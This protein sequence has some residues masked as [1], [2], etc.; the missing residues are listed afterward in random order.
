MEEHRE[1]LIGDAFL[2]QPTQKRRCDQHDSNPRLRKAAINGSHQ[3]LTK[4][5][6]LFA[7]PYR[8]TVLYK[9]VMKLLCCTLSVIPR[10]TQEHIPLIE[11]WRA[12]LKDLPRRS[13]GANFLVGVKDCG[14]RS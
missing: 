3:R 9:V 4:T 8:N 13:E 7:E 14:T 10:V 5:Y 12:A 1:F 11:N 2:R 6:V